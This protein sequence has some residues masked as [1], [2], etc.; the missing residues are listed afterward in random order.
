M[1]DKKLTL[2]FKLSEFACND[3]ANTPV[4][5][6]YMKNVRKLARALQFLRDVIKCAIGINSGFRTPIHNEEEGGEDDSFHLTAEGA[7]IRWADKSISPRF[8][9]GVLETLIWLKLIPQGG[10]GIYRNRIHYDIRGKPARWDN[11]RKK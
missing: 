10:I 9:A 7:D 1:K 2:N 8:V 11:T 4:P 5:K 6:K 3:E